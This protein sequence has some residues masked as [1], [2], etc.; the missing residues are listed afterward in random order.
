LLVPIGV[1]AGKR[2]EVR[3]ISARISTNLPDKFLWDFCLQ[4]FQKKRSSFV[5]LQT[6]GAFFE[7][8]QRWAPFLSAFSGILPGFS[9]N[10]IFG[11]ALAPPPPTPLLVPRVGMHHLTGIWW[12]VES[13]SVV[14]PHIGQKVKG[15]HPL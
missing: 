8:K 14:V 7:I 11:G 3:R 13:H 4:I 5:F 2:L 9:T 12:L 15:K 1:G 6:L 10:Q